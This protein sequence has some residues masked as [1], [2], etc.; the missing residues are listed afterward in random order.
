MICSIY[1]HDAALIC[2]EQLA[3]A[4]MALQPEC[5]LDEPA[6]YCLLLFLLLQQSSCPQTASN[7]PCYCTH[8]YLTASWKQQLLLY[9]NLYTT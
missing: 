1:H 9:C 2:V 4:D 8:S 6:V 3:A 7:R 5:S